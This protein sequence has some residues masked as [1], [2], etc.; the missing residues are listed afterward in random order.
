MKK[1]LF[2]GLVAMVGALTANA[3]GIRAVQLD[4]A[5]QKES[6]AFVKAYAKR[7]ADVG[8]NTL[9]LYLVDRV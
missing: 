6:V 2:L 9:V 1:C 5:R 8:Y 4:L 3:E 7:A